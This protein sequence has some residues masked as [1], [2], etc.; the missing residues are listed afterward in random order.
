M[1]RVLFLLCAV[2][3]VAGAWYWSGRDTPAPERWLGEDGFY[4][5]NSAAFTIGAPLAGIPLP[6]PP[7]PVATPAPQSSSELKDSLFRDPDSPVGGNPEGEIT[8]VEFFDYR[9]AYCKAVAPKLAR[10]VEGDVRIRLIY[11]EWPILGGSSELAA[12]AAL[13]VHRQ[14][15]YDAFHRHMM[16]VSGL[17]T[18]GLIRSVADELG[19]DWA[20]LQQDMADP[21]IDDALV[22]TKR[23][24]Q[25]IGIVGTPAFVAGNTIVQGAVAPEELLSLAEEADTRP[26]IGA[27]SPDA[28]LAR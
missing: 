9:C 14:G 4:R 20:R 28:P 5:L 12:R 3:I 15:K 16:A 8:I 19:L 22:R 23:L 17:P 11:K 27:K 7:D 21:R 10:L 1:A 2:G 13:A 18:M 24:A 25:R 26:D 6:G